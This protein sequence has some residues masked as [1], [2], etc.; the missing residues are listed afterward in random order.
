VI[1]CYYIVIS[2]SLIIVQTALIPCFPLFDRFYDLPV[3]FVVCLGLFCPARESFPVVLAL[4]FA[5][6]SLSGSPPGLYITTYFWLLVVVIW[7]ATFLHI[8]SSFLLPI[9]VASAVLIENAFLISG[10]IL[11]VPDSKLPENIFKTIATQVLWA[12]CTGPF[13]ILIINATHKGWQDWLGEHFTRRN[14]HNV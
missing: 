1:Y 13:L 7:V 2:L 12:V 6:D 9:V 4:G 10:I 11:L 3:L 8:R 14:G 5:M